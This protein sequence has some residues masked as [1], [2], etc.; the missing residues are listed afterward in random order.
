MGLEPVGTITKYYQ[1]VDDHTRAI[2]ESITQDAENF[3]DL[4]TRLGER[5]CSAEAPLSLAF[6]AVVWSW[7]VDGT[8]VR[9]TIAQK[10]GETP[11]IQPWTF[12]S[13]AEGQGLTRRLSDAIEDAVKSGPDDWILMHLLL[14]KMNLWAAT[15]ECINALEAAQS[16][17]KNTPRLECYRP[18]ILEGEAQ[19]KQHIEGDIRGAM[20]LYREALDLAREQDDQHFI[21]TLLLDLADGCATSDAHMAMR[22]IDE[23]YEISTRLG[24][25]IRVRVTLTRMSQISHTLGEYDLALRCLLDAYEIKSFLSSAHLHFPLDIS[26]IYSDLGNGQEALAWALMFEERED[27]GGYGGLPVH[28]CPDIAMARAFLLLERIGDASNCIDRLKEIA[29][30]SGWEPWLAGYYFV[31]GLYEMSMGETTNGMQ[32]VER[33]LEISERLGLQIYVNRCLVALT[34]AE[35]MEY[36]DNESTPD[37]RDSGP[38]MSRLEKEATEKRLTGILMQH[39][40]LKAQFRIKLKQIDAAHE[41][42]ESALDISDQLSVKTLRDQ[43]LD[44]LRELERVSLP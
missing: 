16:L 44:Q 39:G 5:A 40:L 15:P 38:W 8:H 18:D 19:I 6:I 12:P 29:F 13:P 34:K 28:G 30:R 22:L 32:T 4:L 24:I 3:Y 36:E 23:A 25:P 33:A 11:I 9:E 27:G 21:V 17:L 41:T 42:L 2:I 7:Y 43:I 35:I 37:P 20:E 31:S 10:Y 14:L 26:E 1:F